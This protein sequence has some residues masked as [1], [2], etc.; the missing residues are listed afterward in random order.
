MIEPHRRLIVRISV[1]A[2]RSLEEPNVGFM[3]RNHMG[4]D[5]AGTNTVREGVAV[6]PMAPGDIFTVDFHLDIPELYPGNFSFSPAIADGSLEAYEMC[7]WIDNAL[8]L[9]MSR[10]EG[11][12]YGYI[13]LP[14]QI[15]INTP[16]RPKA[17]EPPVS[18]WKG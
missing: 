16:L 8:T 2:R 4:I 15:D 10:G 12:V 1:R 6:P 13:H 7:D 18:S 3:L 14:C 9:P 11:P 5:F 17:A